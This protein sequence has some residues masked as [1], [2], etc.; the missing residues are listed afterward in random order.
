MKKNRPA[1]GDVD[2]FEAEPCATA[3]FVQTDKT[4]PSF[5]VQEG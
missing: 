3:A 2:V 1:N 5:L 4:Y